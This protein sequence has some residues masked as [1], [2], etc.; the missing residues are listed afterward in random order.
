ML[1]IEHHIVKSSGILKYGCSCILV[2]RKAVTAARQFHGLMTHHEGSIVIL[3]LSARMTLMLSS[4]S[5]QVPREDIPKMCHPFLP[6]SYVRGKTQ[7][8]TLRAAPL[9]SLRLNP[10]SCSPMLTY[11][12]VHGRTASRAVNRRVATCTTILKLL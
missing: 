3:A 12:E 4:P 9:L 11:F 8:E 2:L 1:V 6:L 10:T 5:Q 7:S